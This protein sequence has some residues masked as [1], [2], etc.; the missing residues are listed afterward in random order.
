MNEIVIPR[1]VTATAVIVGLNAALVVGTA[2]WPAQEPV[3][4]TTQSIPTF[5]F[6]DKSVVAYSTPASQDFARE[7]VGIY[8]TLSKGQESLGEEFEAVWDANV[9][10]LYEA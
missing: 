5:S 6:F 2:V 10:S 9:N 3:Y 4:V 1:K 7:I 8:T